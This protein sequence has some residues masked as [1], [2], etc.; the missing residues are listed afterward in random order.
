MADE[1]RTELATPKKRLDAIKKGDVAKSPD[2]VAVCVLLGGVLT[3]VATAR[4]RSA[5]A[6][7]YFRTAFSRGFALRTDAETLGASISDAIF[8]TLGQFALVGAVVALCSVAA[9][10]LQSG[11]RFLPEKL[12]PDF[13]RLDPKRGFARI[14][15]ADAAAQ[16]LFGLVKI[17]AVVAIVALAFYRDRET[18]ARLSAASVA[19]LAALFFRFATRLALQLCGTLAA[20]AAVDYF[21]RRWKWERGLRMTPRELRDEIKEEVGDPQLKGKRRDFHRA[22]GAGAAP[23]TD[24]E[25]N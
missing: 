16:T 11:F 14:F 5:F 24:S 3:V 12:A 13:K 15:S 4:A 17:V 7:D 19:E 21:W 9:N 18:F 1:E 8:L 23:P 20:L 10:F 2:A 25:E 22:L 6:F